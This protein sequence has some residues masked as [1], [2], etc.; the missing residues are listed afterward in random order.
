M[1]R[2]SFR[3][4]RNTPRLQ[5]VPWEAGLQRGCA[6]A[7]CRPTPLYRKMKACQE[8]RGKI[9]SKTPLS[10]REGGR[11]RIDP[12]APTTTMSTWCP[13]WCPGRG[14]RGEG[15]L[16]CRS[17]DHQWSGPDRCG[18]FSA[19]FAIAAWEPRGK[20]RPA[21]PRTSSGPVHTDAVELAQLHA[22][23]CPGDRLDNSSAVP[24]PLPAR[25]R[26]W[27]RAES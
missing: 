10:L 20:S 2:N 13:T 21:G 19:F 24:A 6:I 17:P 25:R 22:V 26:S 7:V 8:G 27:R 15:L 4:G 1:V 12:L 14:A 5:R 11:G 3:M 16:P 9:S 18:P 23:V